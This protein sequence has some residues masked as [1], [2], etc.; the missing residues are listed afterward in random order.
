MLFHGCIEGGGGGGGVG[1]KCTESPQGAYHCYVEGHSR[2]SR[3]CEIRLLAV[4]LLAIA[5]FMRCNELV[6]LKLAST[7]RSWWLG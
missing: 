6:Q 3:A 1:L 2:D 5:G 7:L 4:W